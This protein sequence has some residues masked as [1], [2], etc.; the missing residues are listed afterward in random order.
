MSDLFIQ[1][2]ENLKETRISQKAFTDE[3]YKECVNQN[4][5]DE[6]LYNHHERYKKNCKRNSEVAALYLFYYRHKFHETINSSSKKAAWDFYIE[7]SNRVACKPLEGNH[8]CEKSAVSSLHKLFGIWRE[9][10]KKYGSESQDFISF[11]SAYLDDVRPFTSKWHKPIDTEVLKNQFRSELTELQKI[12]SIFVD[13]LKS[14]YEF[15][16]C[17]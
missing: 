5:S 15:D 14:R 3:F 4:A 11:S 16:T 1:L 17:D 12:S 9:I 13:N 7:I 10:C 6:E 8:G 2:K